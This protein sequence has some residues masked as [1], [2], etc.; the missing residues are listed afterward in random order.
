MPS[1]SLSVNQ[2]TAETR[3]AVLGKGAAYGMADDIARAVE[4]LAHHGLVPSDE[5]SRYLLA[6][7]EA[8]PQEPQIHDDVIT[9]TGQLGLADVAVAL[10]YL[11]AFGRPALS[12]TDMLYPHLSLALAHLRQT[13]NF[14]SFTDAAGQSLAMICANQA[15]KHQISHYSLGLLQAQM[16]GH[17]LRV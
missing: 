13:P 8:R 9:I 17:G 3:K 15:H 10:D 6:P 12:M 14:G 5:L 4:W 2:L 11:E 16:R 1:L 7:S